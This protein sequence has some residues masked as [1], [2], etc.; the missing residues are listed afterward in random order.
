MVRRESLVKRF[1]T[2]G[3]NGVRYLWSSEAIVEAVLAASVCCWRRLGVSSVHEIN[4]VELRGQLTNA[5][6]LRTKGF[7][8]VAYEQNFA[9]ILDNAVVKERSKITFKGFPRTEIAV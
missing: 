9:S 4:K 1:V 2:A 5:V 6:R 7:V 3:D 8:K